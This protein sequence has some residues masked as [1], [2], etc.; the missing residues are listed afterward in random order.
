MVRKTIDIKKGNVL[1]MSYAET[2]YDILS[3]GRERGRGGR[4]E[5]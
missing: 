4:D 1:C 5:G 3:C 2:G